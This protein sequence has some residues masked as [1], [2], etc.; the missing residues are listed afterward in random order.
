V[1]EKYGRFLDIHVEFLV[2]SVLNGRFDHVRVAH[3]NL[4]TVLDILQKE[5]LR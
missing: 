1:L 4:H 2:R 3:E 5:A